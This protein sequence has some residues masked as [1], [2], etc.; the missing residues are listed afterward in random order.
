MIKEFLGTWTGGFS[1]PFK[2]FT[3]FIERTATGDE[4][5]YFELVYD[6]GELATE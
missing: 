6:T 5:T 2:T 1:V 4:K 3:D